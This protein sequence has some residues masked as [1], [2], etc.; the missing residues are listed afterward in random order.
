MNDTPTSHLAT[1]PECGGSTVDG[2]TCWEQL[3]ALIAW[4]YDDPELAAEHFLT[5]A[6]YN[7]QHPAQ[8]TDDAIEGLRVAMIERLDNDLP[9]AQIRRRNAAEYEGK[10]RV[11]RP[12]SERRPVLRRWQMTIA[13]VYTPDQREG[14][15]ERVRAWAAAIRSQL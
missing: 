13:D 11:L 7:L 4:E 3:G 14:A 2:L 1:C 6:A 8:F 9:V 5:V 12:E 15:A 10:K